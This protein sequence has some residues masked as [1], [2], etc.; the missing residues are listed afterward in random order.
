M[1]SF[2]IVLSPYTTVFSSA[3]PWAPESPEGPRSYGAN[4]SADVIDYASIPLT[5]F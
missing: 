2:F 1:R 3:G 4:H 5:R